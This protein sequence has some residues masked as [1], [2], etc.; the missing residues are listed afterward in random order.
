MKKRYD[1]NTIP[2]SFEIGDKVFALIPLSGRPL[3][4][5]FHGPY[6]VSQKISDLNYVI[7]TPDRR[8]ATQMC[9]INMLKPY[10]ERG[11][12]NPVLDATGF[13]HTLNHT[14]VPRESHRKE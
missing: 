2:R 5:R 8:K 11:E 1:R 4:A 12:M 14:D 6:E 9:H 3:K 10:Y 7:N 13:V